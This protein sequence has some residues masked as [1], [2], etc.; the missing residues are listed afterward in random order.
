MKAKFRVVSLLLTL[1]LLLCTFSV[2]AFADESTV[3]LGDVD[4]NGKV[5]VGDVA[6]INSYIRT[7]TGLEGYSLLC[8][9]VNGGSLNMGDTAALYAHIRGSKKLY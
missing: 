4:G 9:N 6:K 3:L 8:A 2:T 1:S 7:G 5:N